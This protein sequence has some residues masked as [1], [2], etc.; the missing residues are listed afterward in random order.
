MDFRAT[1][2][3]SAAAALLVCLLG[4]APAARA[5]LADTGAPEGAPTPDVLPQ[6]AAVARAPAGWE[7][8]ATGLPEEARLR[9][10]D[11]HVLVDARET[12]RSKAI[13]VGDVAPLGAGA[14]P[15]LR[16]LKDRP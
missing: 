9:G 2:R 15:D 6:P 5:S 12:G 16:P 10:P 14:V 8:L 13:E 4:T 7:T 1:A 3:S 11:E